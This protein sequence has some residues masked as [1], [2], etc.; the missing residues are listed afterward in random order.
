MVSAPHFFCEAQRELFEAGFAGQREGAGGNVGGHVMKVEGRKVRKRDDGGENT[1][2]RQRNATTRFNPMAP[3]RP[4]QIVRPAQV[5]Y[6][7]GLQS[8]QNSIPLL[9]QVWTE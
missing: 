9:D 3:N 6:Q 1:G 7:R 5:S 8:E 2:S 4:R